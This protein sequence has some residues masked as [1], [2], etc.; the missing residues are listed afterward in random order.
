MRKTTKLNWFSRNIRT[1]R[2]SSIAESAPMQL[3]VSDCLIPD[4]IVINK[5]QRS[6]KTLTGLFTLEAT[7]L[8]IGVSEERSE[9]GPNPDRRWHQTHIHIPQW[10]SLASSLGPAQK[11]F[12]TQLWDRSFAKQKTTATRSP[13]ALF[14]FGKHENDPC[15]KGRFPI[16]KWDFITTPVNPI[17]VQTPVII[18]YPPRNLS[19]LP[20]MM[21]LKCN[22]FQIWLFGLAIHSISGGG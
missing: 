22:S 2:S 17:L 16:C 15:G 18:W 10:T 12:A 19:L 9:A 5:G 6:L 21:V 11:R 3:Q 1:L 13:S 20:N 14:G 7:P 4:Q 8:W